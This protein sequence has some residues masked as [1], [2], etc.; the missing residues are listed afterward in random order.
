MFFCFSQLTV[1]ESANISEKDEL[2]SGGEDENMLLGAD[3]EHR[4]TSSAS[5]SDIMSQND[6]KLM[7]YND[8]VS[9]S[10]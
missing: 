1:S 9:S 2:V 4:T 3:L 5:A 10:G 6:G 7:E 8:A